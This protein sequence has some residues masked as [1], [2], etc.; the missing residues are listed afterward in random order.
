LRFSFF[1]AWLPWRK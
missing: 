1:A